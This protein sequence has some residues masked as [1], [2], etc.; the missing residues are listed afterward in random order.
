MLCNIHETKSLSN[1]FFIRCKFFTI[2]MDENNDILDHINKVKSLADQLTCLEVPM[3]N[4][5][6]VLTLLDSLP[7]SFDHLI[8]ALKTRLMSELTLDFITTR[9]MHEVSKRKEKELQRDDVTMLSRQAR[10]FDNNKRRGNVPR[11]YNCGKLDHIARICRMKRKVNAN[12]TRLNDDFA[13]F[14]RDGTSTTSATRWIVNSG[15]SQHMTPH[16]Q[17]FATYKSILG[18]K[19]FI[20]DNG[21]VEAVGKGSI[22]VETRVKDR[23]RSI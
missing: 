23:T 18:H 9:L 6:V 7:P 2:K 4:E 8:T 1:I 20:G 21:M 14:V 19:V 3:K 5:D 17:F 12:M 11:C 22:L 10:T 15:A 13:F 16:K